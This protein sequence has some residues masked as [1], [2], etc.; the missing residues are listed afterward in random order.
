MK[1]FRDSNLSGLKLHDDGADSSPEVEVRFRG[2]GQYLPQVFSAISHESFRCVL[3]ASRRRW[4]QT[5]TRIGWPSVARSLG[6]SSM[7]G[8][9]MLLV[10]LR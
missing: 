5:E 4:R 9:Y 6:S 7:P 2:R 1:R 10:G 3:A 8:P